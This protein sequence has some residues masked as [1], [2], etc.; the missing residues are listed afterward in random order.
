MNISNAIPI[1]D[2]TLLKNLSK[3]AELHSC[4]STNC[5]G[6]ENSLLRSEPNGLSF[7]V[8]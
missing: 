7:D 1:V 5:L 8:K 3:S 4:Y 2:T 6:W